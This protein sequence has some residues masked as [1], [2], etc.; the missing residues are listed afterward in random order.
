MARHAPCS[1]S[2][3]RLTGSAAGLGK[4]DRAEQGV[5][6][7]ARVE[8]CLLYDDRDVGLDRCREVSASGHRLRGVKLVDA[9]VP[10]TA[11]RHL[12]TVGPRWL[13]IREVEPE[14]DVR[15]AV[16]RVQQ[17][18]RLVA[19]HFGLGPGGAR[20]DVTLR[21]RQES[22]T[23][24]ACNYAAFAEQIG[25]GG[26]RVEA[27]DQVAPAWDE[28]LAADRPVVVDALTDPEIPPLPPH[29]TLDQ[30]RSLTRAVLAGDPESRR[31]L[32]ES[33]RGKLEEFL[34]FRRKE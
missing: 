6:G 31:I 2:R 8:P 22:Q 13:A 30:A 23:L 7:L 21:Q 19:R 5:F 3:S 33:L 10:G 4:G 26:I 34:P 9:H 29:V 28:A 20:R 25:L 15:R 16:A 17:T 12:D 1:P 27:T 11:G 24:P 18:D 32:R 14:Q